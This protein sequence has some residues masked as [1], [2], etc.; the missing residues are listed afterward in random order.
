MPTVPS[1]N[2]DSRPRCSVLD[3]TKTFAYDSAGNLSQYTDADG[4]A[5]T[6]Q[7]DSA[8]NVSGETWYPT[9]EDA[10]NAE[11][12]TNAI[13]YARDSAG[14]ITSEADANSADTYAYDSAG[15]LASA[16]ESLPDGPTV[17]LTYQYDSAGNRTQM[18]STID[19]VADFVDDYTYD[20]AGDVISVVEHGVTGGDAVA[21]K[22]IDLTYNSDG[23]LATVDRYEDGVLAVEGDYTYDSAGELVGLVYRQGDTVLASYAWTYSG[24]TATLSAGSSNADWLPSGGTVPVHDT[25]GVTSAL[26][27][28]GY[29]GLDEVT[30]CTSVDGTASYSYDP[31]GQLA[32]A[33]YSGGQADESYTYDA[34]GNRVTANGDVYATGADNELLSDGTYT[35]AYDAE[36]NRTAKFIDAN[37]DGVLDVGDTD[38]T[39]YT[40]D[41]R[42]RLVEVKDYATEGGSPTEVVDYLYDVEDRWIGENIFTGGT[43]HQI[44]FA[45]DGNEIVLQFDKDGAGTLDAS[46]LSHRYTWLPNAVDQLMSDE[47]LPPPPVIQGQGGYDRTQPGKVVWALADNLGTVR[48]LAVRDA[49]TGITS[50][51]N[52]RV[53][54]SFGNLKLAINPLTNQ[55]ATVDCL[56]GFTGLPF[57]KASGT[58]RSATRPYDPSAGRWLDKDWI[59]FGGGVT[60]LYSYVGNSPTNRKDPSGEVFWIPVVIFVGWWIMDGG[61]GNAHAPGNDAEAAAANAMDQARLKE[62][63]VE[64]AEDVSGIVTAGIS[65]PIGEL[66]TDITT[67]PS[68]WQVVKKEIIASTNVRNVGGTSVQELLRNTETGE[69]I[70]RHTLLKAN[71]S[72]FE[73][74]HYR[75]SWK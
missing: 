48:D 30:S 74:P 3:N 17:V 43:E 15:N 13:S 35:Y 44:R 65:R 33:T 26:M 9:A 54:D 7:Y 59:T 47:Q 64:T 8:G 28:G 53:F 16:T 32:S 21:N 46:N 37:H 41:N 2:K 19:G 24:G 67:N 71:G 29:A 12:P 22:E 31:T 49:Q 62:Q 66:I 60:N 58:Y 42:D 55:L 63:V 1:R 27:S 73:I 5:N 38:V 34:N 40:W 70:V 18:A 75:P 4:R 20:S 45:Y 56:F 36:G 69:E 6:Y 72:L 68:V 25:T 61:A 52:H 57:D 10:E 39:E 14:R 50:V 11:D 23:E 51:V